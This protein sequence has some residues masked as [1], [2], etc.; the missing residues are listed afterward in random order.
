MQAF[1][2]AGP[3][4]FL[5]HVNPARLAVPSPMPNSAAIARQERCCARSAANW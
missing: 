3:D 4:T 1:A 5:A 2:G